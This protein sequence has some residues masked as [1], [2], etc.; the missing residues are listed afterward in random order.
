[1]G[2]MPLFETLHWGA[3]LDDVDCITFRPR[4]SVLVCREKLFHLLFPPAPYS[5]LLYGV[6]GKQTAQGRGNTT[7]SERKQQYQPHAA[8][9][10]QFNDRRTGMQMG[11]GRMSC[12]QP[13]HRTPR[14]KKKNTQTKRTRHPTTTETR[15]RFITNVHALTINL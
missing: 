1:M 12:N 4:P 6:L 13:N 7:S 9:S 2:V 3:L 15:Y 14:Q 5:T 8:A 10:H 11:E